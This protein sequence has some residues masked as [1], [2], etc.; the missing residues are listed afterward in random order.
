M[1]TALSALFSFLGGSVFRMIWGEV[2]AILHQR[3]ERANAALDHA[4]ELA[5]MEA[6]ERINAAQ[7]ERNLGAQR[8]QAELGVQVI[9]VQGETD[10]ARIE[11]LT[12]QQNDQT[13]GAAVLQALK[14]T[15]I[16]LVDAW[17]ASIRPAAASMALFL[18]F[19][20]LQIQNFVMAGRDWDLV[21]AILGFFFADRTLAKRGK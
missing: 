17:N 8:L 2:S 5:M 11:A 9:R 13:W 1:L 15:G 14:P 4:H 6:Q 18:W 7:H 10:L 20:A 19:R 3:Q 21:C 12:E 16:W